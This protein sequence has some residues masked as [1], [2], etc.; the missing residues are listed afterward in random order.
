MSL[1][2]YSLDLERDSSQYAEAPDSASLSVAG[3]ST[4]EI[5]GKLET[6]P[7]V[8]GGAYFLMGKN[9]DSAPV[10][11]REYYF[12]ISSDADKLTFLFRDSSDN[13]TV[14]QSN[15]SLLTIALWRHLAA[16]VDVSVPSV[17]FYING[18]AVTSNSISTAATSM[19]DGDEPFRIGAIESGGVTGFADGKFCYAAIWNTI[20][21]PS[22]VLT[23]SRNALNGNESGLAAYWRLNNSLLD[24]TAN[25][26][27]L[28]AV[29]TPVFV[30]D[31]PPLFI[32]RI[33]GPV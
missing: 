5:W 3:D 23:D 17:Q 22:Q 31:V 2:L 8:A 1:N 30:Q 29:N 4:F 27:D 16:T 11:G 25:N 14:F 13:E 32:P 18:S 33:I 6:L 26:N 9:R 15:G 10:G 28:T 19:R 12:G 7:S 21:T 24:E 20:R